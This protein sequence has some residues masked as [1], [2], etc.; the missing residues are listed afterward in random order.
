MKKIILLLVCGVLFFS[1]NSLLAQ[2]NTADI[3]ETTF[4]DCFNTE[5][6][7]AQNKGV[8]FK[9]A[10]KEAR[11]ICNL[12]FKKQVR[13]FIS[14][15]LTSGTAIKLGVNFNHNENYNSNF[16]FYINHANYTNFINNFPSSFFADDVREEYTFTSLGADYIY[17]GWTM[18]ANFG[19][20]TFENIDSHQGISYPIVTKNSSSIFLGA[21]IGYIFF[22]R[23]NFNLGIHYF[24]N[25]FLKPISYSVKSFYPNETFTFSRSEIS[26]IKFEFLYSF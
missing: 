5:K 8:R 13:F 18:G 6:Q 4:E 16:R 2:D 25:Y 1:G 7:K 10:V 19:K 17:R 26:D 23:K 9:K 11:I 14:G 12:K 22:H 3:L 15:G 21:D 20:A 24:Y